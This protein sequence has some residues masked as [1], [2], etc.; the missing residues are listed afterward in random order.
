MATL[1]GAPPVP[2][3][4]CLG[5]LGL[6]DGQPI[7]IGGGHRDAVG[8]E[9]HERSGQNRAALVARGGAL[10]ASNHLTEDSAIGFE[11]L[12]VIDLGKLRELV[13]R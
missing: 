10:D 9:A 11:D 2:A 3:R 12:L 1:S 7:G 6:G 4:R 5:E 13:D 8:L